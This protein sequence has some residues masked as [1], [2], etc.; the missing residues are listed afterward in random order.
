MKPYDNK[1]TIGNGY[2][3]KIEQE[4]ILS[5]GGV[6]FY[7]GAHFPESKDGPGLFLLR[8]NI[9]LDPFLWGET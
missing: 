6:V 5:E 7:T 4:S 8:I 9:I 2:I 1:I 3:A